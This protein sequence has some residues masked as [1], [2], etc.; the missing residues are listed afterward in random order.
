MGFISSE[1]KCQLEHSQWALTKT[2]NDMTDKYISDF[3]VECSSD[4]YKSLESSSSSEMVDDTSSSS[5][6]PLL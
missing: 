4:P 2:K 3:V 1:K 6:L 5:H